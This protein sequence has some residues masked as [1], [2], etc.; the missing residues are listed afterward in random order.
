ME[1]IGLQTEIGRMEMD[2]DCL[3]HTLEASTDIDQAVR[4]PPPNPP[5]V[6]PCFLQLRGAFVQDSVHGFS[7]PMWTQTEGPSRGVDQVVVT[8]LSSL[9][10]PGV[11]RV[12][13][14]VCPRMEASLMQVGTAEVRR[15]WRWSSLTP[16]L[17]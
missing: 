9:K 4:H 11:F 17:L 12:Y 2:I 14:R 6:E 15:V 7:Y 13:S 16:V 1:A 3:D 10:N 8:L 5:I